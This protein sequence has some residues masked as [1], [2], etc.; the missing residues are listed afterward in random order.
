MRVGV[1]RNPFSHGNRSQGEVARPHDHILFAQPASSEA[2][3]KEV[4]RFASEGIDLLVIDGGD[5]TVREV[6]SAL[7]A[8]F[9][10]GPPL[11]SVLPSGKTNVL[12]FDLGARASW[13]L[14]AVLAA[15]G[16]PDARIRYRSP[17][18]VAREGSDLPHRGFVFGAAGF[19]RARALAQEVHRAR[20]FKNAS[21]AL[22]MMGALAQLAIGSNQGAWRRGEVLS[23]AVDDAPPRKGARLVTMATT[24]NRLPFLMRP[25]GSS[26]PGL[27]VLDVDAPPRSLA[28]ALPKILWGRGEGW[29][30]AHGYRRGDAQRLHLTLD[31]D[32][33]LDGEVF[34]GGA[35]T[36]TQAAALRFLT[37]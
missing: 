15:M 28:R 3:A 14:D 26:R 11:L 1:I 29:L 37:P 5:G 6:L 2:V 19:V 18:D 23:L 20:V 34:P 7:P 9:P 30:A 21:V 22:T 36:I 13:T 10:D 25:F 33:V 17:L 16:N 31:S 27:K 32:V 8:A 12:A 24:L 4:A 35:L